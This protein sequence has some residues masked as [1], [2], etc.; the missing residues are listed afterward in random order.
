MGPIPDI[1]YFAVPGAI[2]TIRARPVITSSLILH[3]GSPKAQKWDEA[4]RSENGRLYNKLHNLTGNDHDVYLPFLENKSFVKYNTEWVDEIIKPLKTRIAKL[5]L[6]H[7]EDPKIIEGPISEWIGSIYASEDKH[8]KAAEI[9]A[10]ILDVNSSD[11]PCII[12]WSN[13]DNDSLIKILPYSYDKLA[14]MEKYIIGIYSALTES[15]RQQRGARPDMNNLLNRIEREIENPENAIKNGYKTGLRIRGISVAKLKQSVASSLREIGECYKNQYDDAILAF[16][17]E[18]K[19]ISPK[20]SIIMAITEKRKKIIKMLQKFGF[21]LARDGG[22]HEIWQ[23]PKLKKPTPVP[24][25]IITRGV[26][27]SIM[28]D[29]R[30]VMAVG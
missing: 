23:H 1:S 26:W 6:D 22:G 9:A 21:F 14:S 29:I 16:E 17:E 12:L 5:F 18:V 4:L 3:N 20:K 28:D 7:G 30:A 8:Y 24:R 11:L 15:S 25:H 27:E 10:K 13:I 2:E 19:N